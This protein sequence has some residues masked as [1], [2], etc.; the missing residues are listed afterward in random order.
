MPADERQR[1]NDPLAGMELDAEGQPVHAR[2]P[3]LDR[4]RSVIR[5]PSYEKVRN[6][7]VLY[8]HASRVLH[9]ETNPPGEDD[10]TSSHLISM[11]PLYLMR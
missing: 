2:R 3:R 10:H 4:S 6:D 7:A 11:C 5:L 8:A 1:R 9:Q